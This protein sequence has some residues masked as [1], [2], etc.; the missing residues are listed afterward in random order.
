MKSGRY[1]AAEL[2]DRTFR[3]NS[4]SNIMLGSAAE[5]IE[6]EIG[7]K[8]WKFCCALYHGVIE[9][10]ITLDYIIGGLSSRPIEKLDTVILNILRTGIYQIL[11][12]DSV[13]DSAAVNESVKLAREF[14]KSSASGMINAVLRN[15]IRNGRKYDIPK[16]NTEKM[17]V[18][19][20]TDI[21]LVESLIKD[22]GEEKAENLLAD[23]LG[24]PPIYIRLNNLAVTEED[25]MKSWAEGFK[26]EKSEI[27]PYCYRV[28]G[29]YA[30]NIE[31]EDMFGRGR[32]HVQDMASQLCCL[33]LNPNENDTVID[34]CAAPGGKTFTMAEMMNGKGQVR[35]FD[36]H[37]HRVR[38]IDY[39]IKA[40]GL[41]N[42]TAEVG[43]AAVYNPK[44]TGCT[45]I[46]CDVP[47]SGIGT[48]RR[49]PEIKYKNPEDFEKL[50]DIQY[51]VAENAINYLADGGEMVYS[52][53]TLRRAENDEVVEKLIENHPEME[54][55]RLPEPL[56]DK[57]DGAASIFPM[58]FGSDGFFIAKLRK[59]GR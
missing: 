23:S 30:E 7:A 31:K 39:G 34:M 20:S 47:C 3:H 8:E 4:Y 38:L 11:Y 13:P 57:F 41:E 32:F 53:C 19:Y 29:K 43:D 48:I 37:R 10:K 16:D 44:I 54:L 18:E 36:I 26:P 35:S 55:V 40:L 17:S 6:P 24:E 50:P 5:K 21:R 52:T 51:A 27:I 2:L 59:K 1:F 15:F 22:Y 56:G 58:H 45:K 14:K 12:M 42:V 49:K 46:L 33:A 28:A 9:R 25:F